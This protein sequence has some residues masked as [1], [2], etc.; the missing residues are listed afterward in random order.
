MN[1]SL[2]TVIYCLMTASLAITYRRYLIDEGGLLAWIPWIVNRMLPTDYEKWNWF[3]KAFEKLTVVCA[4]CQAGQI[5][6]WMAITTGSTFIGSLLCAGLSSVIAH[7]I[8]QRFDKSTII[9]M[10]NEQLIKALE[11]AAE[12]MSLQDSLLFGELLKRFKELEEESN[13][14][15]QSLLESKIETALNQMQ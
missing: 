1:H 15:R 10:T 13:Q 7:I 5:S 14:L 11:P 8:D 9:K 2:H 3:H 6:F 12:A 4:T